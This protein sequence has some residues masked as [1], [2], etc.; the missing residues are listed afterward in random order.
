MLKNIVQLIFVLFIA[1]GTGCSNKKSYVVNDSVRNSAEQLTELIKQHP[2]DA[3]L[4]YYRASLYM[5]KGDGSAALN[6]M[7]NAVQIDSSKTEYFFLLGDI[8]FSKLFIAQA[9]SSFE[10]SI[11]LDPK[12]ITAELKLAELFL[13]LK[14]YQQS[15]DHADNALRIDKTNAKAYF[16]KGFMFKETGDTA[17][18]IS[19]FQTA[20][21]QNPSYF[22]AYIQLGNLLSHK[23]NNLALNYYDHALQ[24]NKDAPDA[25]YGKAMYYQEN[26]SVEAAE[27]IYQKIL[28]TNP[29]YKEAL[30]NLGYI[31]LLYRS[32]YKTAIEYFNAVCR[33]DTND[34]RA[35]YN[36]GLSFEQM[37]KKDMAEADY[38]LAL[39]KSPDYELAKEGLKR[40]LK[41]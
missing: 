40:L 2:D 29:D 16:I 24:I 14:K 8:Y 20:V 5:K 7:L 36:R 37:N 26:D 19:S 15:L 28:E 38:R 23:K 11:A 1:F 33:L 30:F 31:A 34:V 32:D 6:D 25:L 27:K 41:K 9:V 18:A 10:K 12:N 13:L 3:N 17:R 4:Y 21:E 39:R 22:D 35:F